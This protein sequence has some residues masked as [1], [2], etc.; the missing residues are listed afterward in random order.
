MT[1]YTLPTATRTSLVPGVAKAARV[2]LAGLVRAS[3]DA[4]IDYR[5]AKSPEERRHRFWMFVLYLSAA[6]LP[7]GA[8]LVLLR[9]IWLRFHM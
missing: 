5:A 1:A 3:R 6:I 4:W 9:W 8:L 2:W 7:G